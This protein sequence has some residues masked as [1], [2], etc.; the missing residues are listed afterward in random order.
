[1]S[2]SKSQTKAFGGIEVQEFININNAKI[3]NVGIPTNANDAATKQ[4]VDNNIQT[5]GIYPGVGLYRSGN[6]F[7]VSTDLSHVTNFGTIQ[8]GTWGANVIGVIYGGTGRSSFTSNK[9][10]L[11]NGASNLSSA[12]SLSIDPSGNFNIGTT[13]NVFISSTQPSTGLGTGGALTVLGGASFSRS[14]QF[15]EDLIVGGSINISSDM[16]VGNIVIRGSSTFNAVNAA[17]SQFTNATIANVSTTNALTTNITTS[18]IRGTTSTF[19]NNSATISTI[20]NLLCTNS[21]NINTSTTTLSVSGVSIFTTSSAFSITTNN[22]VATSLTTNNILVGISLTTPSLRTTNATIGALNVSS[23]NLASINT[24]N[25]SNSNSISTGNLIVSQSAN[26]PNVQSTAIT[27]TNLIANNITVGSNVITTNLLASNG[28]F[29]NLITSTLNTSTLTTGS[30]ISTSISTNNI[31][32]LNITTGSI[33]ASTASVSGLLNNSLLNVSNTASIGSIVINGGSVSSASLFSTNFVTQNISTSNLIGSSATIANTLFVPKVVSQ[34]ISTNVITAPSIISSL[35]TTGSV[36]SNNV[37]CVTLTS[38]NI[39]SNN[40]LSTSINSTF[41]S[42]GTLFVNNATT[43]NI[44]TNSLR[45]ANITTTLTLSSGSFFA[46]SSTSVFVNSSTAS[47]LNCSLNN[48]TTSNLRASGLSILNSVVAVSLSTGSL[49]SIDNSNVNLYSNT[50]SINSI[51]SQT[52]SNTSMYNARNFV[53]GSDYSADVSSTSGAFLTV[54]PALFT[55]I[56][57]TS[58]NTMWTSNYIS[59]PTLIALNSNITTEKASN[60]YIQSSPVSGANQTILYKS[61]LA[62]GYV[63]NQTGGYLSGQIMFER[64]DGNWFGSIYTEETTNKII[65]ANASVAGGG[66]IGIYTYTNTPITFSHVSNSASMDPKAFASFTYSTSNLFSTVNSTS[67]TTGSLILKGGMAV[68]KDFYSANIVTGNISKS[69]GT[70]D[71]PHPLVTTKRLVHSFIEGPRCDLIYRGK[72]QLTDGKAVV[73][74]DTDCVESSDCAMTS[75]TFDVLTKNPVFYL[76]NET[77]FD[78]V[79]GFINRNILTIVCENATNSSDIIHW[80]VIAER[81]DTEIHMWN[82]TNTDGCLITEYIVNNTS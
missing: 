48:I 81:N 49:W 31:S 55:D 65:L 75:G 15:G 28:T 51:T 72:V 11:G 36:F 64:Q 52:I 4:Y 60:L 41:V 37:N 1:M 56:N 80:Q 3:S 18:N 46:S 42:T 24:T 67:L 12:D 27:T 10:V 61:A 74:L 14:V 22:L 30:L 2:H 23:A 20:S 39:I 62:L 40:L 21:I 73:D 63:S 79:K 19:T 35:I 68:A 70:F 26:I 5:S 78:R 59:V 54:L 38:G 82:K 44:T 8:T 6:T 34:N 71:I 17:N 57:S 77:G 16:T 29:N 7:N 32:T 50:G 45:V 33:S 25:I 9:L 43:T 66:G 13:A 69:S 58:D 53:I 76:Q 47:I